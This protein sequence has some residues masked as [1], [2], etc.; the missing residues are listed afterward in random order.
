MSQEKEILNS[1]EISGMITR[2]VFQ[3]LESVGSSKKFGI[4]GI[5]NGGSLLARRI[6]TEIEKHTG[7]MPETGC[8]DIT[9]YRD[10]LAQ[11]Q[12]ADIPEVKGTEISFDVSGMHIVL[13]DD[14]IYT[15]RTIRAAL[16]ALTDLGRPS[17]IN[18][19][20]LIDRGHRELPIQPDFMGKLVPTAL[21]ENIKVD[22]KE[23]TG[24]D[25]VKIVKK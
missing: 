13:V 24:V 8:L 18:L 15:G 2:I 17:K 11:T 6:A 21:N 10:D 1:S 3:I 20:V 9:L 14:V 22:F 7:I 4:V 12:I 5:K 23:A 16:D 19:T 25:S